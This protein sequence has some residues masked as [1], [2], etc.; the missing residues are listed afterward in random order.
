MNDVDKAQ[1]WIDAGLSELAKG[2]VEGVRVEVL[3]ERLGVTK[4]GFYRQFKDRRALL[5]AMLDA[6]TRGRIA[7]M[8]KQM[9]RGDVPASE[10]LKSLVRLYAER[11]N[12]KGMAIELA[13]RQWARN[14][15]AAATAAAK[16]DAARMRVAKQL[17]V[18]LGLA[19]PEA[20]ARAALLYSFV[21]G[22]SLLYFGQ[23]LRK[24]AMLDAASRIL[25]NNEAPGLAMA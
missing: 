6:W 21:F 5:L 24:G 1:V 17:Y 19:E 14:D 3:A 15:S 12:V 8:E 10:H 4:G 18:E 11:M 23:T 25:V 16:V 9:E 7:V 2:G 22:Q 13:I 20:Q